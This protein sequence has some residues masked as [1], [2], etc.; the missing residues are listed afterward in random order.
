MPKT[1]NAP[2]PSIFGFLIAAMNGLGSALIIVI[3]MMI[4]ADII[5][6]G[7]FG[8][9]VAGVAEMVSL[10]I[11]AIVFLQL[12]Q[13]VRTNTLARTNIVLDTVKRRSPRLARVIN[14]FYD[15][16]AATLFS[17]LLYGS[18]GKLVD[19]W[20]SN[21]HVG[22][23]G[24][25]VAPVWPVSVVVVIG[26]ATAAMQFLVLA[27]GNFSGKTDPNALPEDSDIS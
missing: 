18:W 9:P 10:T 15:L 6:R 8:T 19:T 16:A 13:A 23:Y 27:Y 2:Q 11:V 5:G 14:G 1:E 12:G 25:F 3:T 7:F 26:A 24:L 21:E 17:L 22:T 20:T 4:C